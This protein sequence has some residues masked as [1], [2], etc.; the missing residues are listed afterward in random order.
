MHYVAKGPAAV[1]ISHPAIV[2]QWV[3]DKTKIS[4]LDRL[5][6]WFGSELI[7]A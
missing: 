1:D 3:N 7:L 6:N 5:I 2:A 4:E